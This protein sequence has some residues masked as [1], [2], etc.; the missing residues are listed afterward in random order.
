[1]NKPFFIAVATVL[2]LVG[3]R[4]YAQNT[5]QKIG[6]TNIDYI[7]A[8]HPKSKQIE[9]QLG[10]TRTQYQNA[11]QEKYKTY[12]D[13]VTAYQKG[14]SQMSEVIRT[15]REKELQTMQTSIQEFQQNA[16]AE[17][18]KKQQELLD[19]V[20]QEI[21]KAVKDVA[22]EN[23]Y[24]YVVNTD[25]SPQLTPVLLYVTEDFNITDLVFKKMGIT[26]PKP[27]DTKPAAN[28]PATGS[29]TPKPGTPTPKK[30]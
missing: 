3:G 19:P 17:L 13:K 28:A 5:T 23:G 11:L 29:T 15:D 2:A 26:P 9:T 6:Y 8:N 16:D 1:M 4:S 18:Q 20:L 30:N 25:V 27:G 24:T 14:A 21:D 12:Q 22:K 7:V 10:T